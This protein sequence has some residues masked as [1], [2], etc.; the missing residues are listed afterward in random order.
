MALLESPAPQIGSPMPVFE[1]MDVTGQTWHCDAW[2]EA[3]VL[4]VMFICAHCP[5]VQAVEPRYVALARDFA[6]QA[7]QFVGICSNDAT[8]YPDDAPQ[9]LRQRAE[10]YGY[11]F[12]YLV[13]DTQDV[14][15]AFGAVCT[16]EF[17]V[18]GPDRKLC[19]HGRLDDNWREPASA[20]QHD[21]RN[22]IRAALA[23]NPPLTPQYPSMGCS[24]KW[25]RDA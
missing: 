3:Q 12:P 11:S 15:R 8:D 17:R 24:I 2:A 7:V 21:L 5:Y 22:A 25:K 14:A 19:Y 13:D 4:V 16:P 18:Y 6:D 1:L 9:A 23:G 10:E 20:T